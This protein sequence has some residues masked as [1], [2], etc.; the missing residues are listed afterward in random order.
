MHALIAKCLS[1]VQVCEI[2]LQAGAN[3]NA[4]DCSG[5]TALHH[6]I[7]HHV[8][9]DLAALLL[10]HGADP[11][12]RN[13]Y[14][15]NALLLPTMQCRMQLCKLL[16]DAGADPTMADYDGCSP[17]SISKM[18]P[19]VTTLFHNPWESE[20]GKRDLG[21]GRDA[22]VS[23]VSCEQEVPRLDV[24]WCPGCQAPYCGPGDLSKS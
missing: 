20:T 15:S 23:C 2:L 6:A 12:A 7:R 11:N 5:C 16:Y 18:D 22:L 8:Q 21:K 9:L 10:Q 4:K 17:I 24:K 3:V 14:G 19:K 13:R 1:P